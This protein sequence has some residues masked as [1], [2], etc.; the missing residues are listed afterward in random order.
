MHQRG[1]R[2]SGEGG[3][4]TDNELS[5][6]VDSYATKHPAAVIS[7]DD[8]TRARARRGE[9]RSSLTTNSR[10]AR[11]KPDERRIMHTHVR[12]FQGRSFHLDRQKNRRVQREMEATR[13]SRPV[14]IQSTDRSCV[15]WRAIKMP[16]IALSAGWKVW[17]FDNDPSRMSATELCAGFQRL[18]AR[19]ATGRYRIRC[20]K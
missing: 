3:E 18:S 10:T 5:L 6:P 2:R 19:E 13:D 16:P 1:R 17:L 15:L 8:I 9:E 14:Q 11:N 7:G 12:T 20:I 4:T